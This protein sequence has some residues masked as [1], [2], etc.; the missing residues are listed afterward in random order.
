MLGHLKINRAIATRY[1]HFAGTFLAVILFDAMQK[2]REANDAIFQA[3][4][5]GQVQFPIIERIESITEQVAREIQR[6]KEEE[7]EIRR[8]EE[9]NRREMEAEARRFRGGNELIP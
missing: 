1:D 2:H 3:V 6:I 9:E 4:R 5:E 7:S 8:A